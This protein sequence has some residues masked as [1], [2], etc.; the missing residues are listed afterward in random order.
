VK[1]QKETEKAA[2][3]HRERELMAANHPTIATTVT[4]TTTVLP[5]GA[6]V[7]QG[8]ITT[9]SV[10]PSA[11][12]VELQQTGQKIQTAGQSLSQASFGTTG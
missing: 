1:A 7:T 4:P 10:Q 5:G 3:V 6:A 2:V 11:K 12:F 8:T 9:T